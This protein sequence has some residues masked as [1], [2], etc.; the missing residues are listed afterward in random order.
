MPSQADQDI[1]L[2]HSLKTTGLGSKAVVD[3][4]VVPIIDLSDERAAT[5]LWEAATKVGFFTVVFRFGKN[6]RTYGW[7]G[8]FHVRLPFPRRVGEA[9]G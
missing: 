6:L 2:E 3:D 1:A 9:T 8:G 7:H 5:K 4:G